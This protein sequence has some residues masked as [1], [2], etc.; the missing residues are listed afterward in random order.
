MMSI[1]KSTF[2]T[3]KKQ[4]FTFT[5]VVALKCFVEI[6]EQTKRYIDKL[7]RIHPILQKYSKT[8]YVE[9]DTLV[10]YCATMQTFQ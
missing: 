10:G 6:F 9:C 5:E 8:F 2:T 4:L 7:L 1:S 3:F